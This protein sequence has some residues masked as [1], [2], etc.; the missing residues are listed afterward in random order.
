MS[1]QTQSSGSANADQQT[2]QIWST[3]TVNSKTGVKIGNRSS[4]YSLTEAFVTILSALMGTLG[5]SSDVPTNKDDLYSKGCQTQSDFLSPMKILRT[6]EDLDVQADRE[7]ALHEYQK[8][9]ALYDPTAKKIKYID[10][11]AFNGENI[12]ALIDAIDNGAELNDETTTK[13]KNNMAFVTDYINWL[14]E[15]TRNDFLILIESEK[16]DGKKHGLTKR[17]PKNEGDGDVESDESFQKRVLQKNTN[18][19]FAKMIECQ[20]W[21]NGVGKMINM[22]FKQDVDTGNKT[23][24]LNNINDMNAQFYHG[25]PSCNMHPL[26]IVCD[27]ITVLSREEYETLSISLERCLTDAIVNGKKVEEKYNLFHDEQ[28]KFEVRNVFNENVRNAILNSWHG[29]M[30]SH[31]FQ[32]TNKKRMFSAIKK[33][34]F[35]QCAIATEAGF[36]VPDTIKEMYAPPVRKR[37]RGE[38]MAKKLED[39]C[40]RLK[41]SDKVNE[42]LDLITKGVLAICMAEGNYDLIGLWSDYRTNPKFA[43]VVVETCS[44]RQI[45]TIDGRDRIE[46]TKEEVHGWVKTANEATTEDA[47]EDESSSEG[48]LSSDDDAADEA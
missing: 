29:N 8:Y 36:N 22:L 48:S 4:D 18:L 24:F 46:T 34:M 6:A 38:T 25:Y 15:L 20:A 5:A 11:T 21:C 27:R 28:T 42:I 2:D 1:L 12:T 14:L 35:E 32:R 31:L 13:M 47:E 7:S 16:L 37:K 39:A 17:Q 9:E 3:P 33:G 26:N 43:N 44:N 41:T 40:K 10:P 19:A 45:T 23:N 30:A